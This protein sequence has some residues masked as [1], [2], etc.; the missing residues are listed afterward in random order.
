M[1]ERLHAGGLNKQ[2]LGF[3]DDALRRGNLIGGIA[4][5][6]V[7]IPQMNVST[8]EK[9]SMNN[10]CKLISRNNSFTIYIIKTGT[11]EK[12]ENGCES[13][14]KREGRERKR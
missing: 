13:V 2:A 6:Q 5:P 7:R 10:A 9:K 1:T 4:L 8:K 11:T 12:T 14:T 3:V